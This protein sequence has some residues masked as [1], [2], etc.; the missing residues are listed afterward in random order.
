MSVQVIAEFG[1]S[2][3]GDLHTAI[4]Q[5]NVAVDAGCAYAKWQMFA[6]ERIASRHARRYWDAS[7]GGSDSQ[8]QTFTYNGM[9]D[10]IGWR[11]LAEHCAGIGLGFLVTPFDLEAI[12]LLEDIGVSA[13]KIASGDV[14]Y[15]QLLKRVAETGKRVFLSTGASHFGEVE[16]ALEWLYPC[17]VT[18]L[19]CTLSYPCSVTDANLARISYLR[20][21]VHGC[22]TGYSDHT[23]RTD[24]ALAAAAL[25][26]TVLEKHATLQEGGPVPDDK[27]ALG[28]ER[29]RQYVAY[30]NIGHAMWGEERLFV[31]MAE[32]PARRGARRSLYAARDIPAGHL[33]QPGDFTYL[34]PCP[35][36]AYEPADAERLYGTLSVTATREGDLIQ[37]AGRGDRQSTEGSS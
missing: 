21:A 9:L 15:K 37:R 1:Q 14:T 2:H 8:L 32:Q 10:P 17:A 34:R 19:A 20:R 11:A 5:A 7:L 4:R 26:A 24:T 29:L 28:P 30:A 13:Y 23:L 36:G 3:C 22:E 6:P 18:L 33:Y 31:V 12:D 16:R 27:M 25:G 35:P